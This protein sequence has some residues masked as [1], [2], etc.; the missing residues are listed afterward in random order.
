MQLWL[1]KE[2]KRDRF[3]LRPYVF[4]CPLF[5]LRSLFIDMNLMEKGTPSSYF[6]TALTY[7]ETEGMHS[8]LV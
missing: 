5:C 2:V 4:S 7:L 8:E 1:Q 3:R 6:M